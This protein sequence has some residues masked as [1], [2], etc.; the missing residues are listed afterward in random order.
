MDSQQ[1]GYL[2]TSWKEMGS[3]PNIQNPWPRCP[4]PYLLLRHLAQGIENKLLPWP[5]SG[6]TARPLGSQLLWYGTNS[7]NIGHNITTNMIGIWRH[8][9]CRVQRAAGGRWRQWRWCRWRGW[10]RWGRRRPYLE[11]QTRRRPGTWWVW[12]TTWIRPT[13]GGQRSSLF[14]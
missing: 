10:W 2:T 11:P 8:W 5:V 14:H 1:Q 13:P 7:A 9:P 3:V 12:W 6:F 4:Q